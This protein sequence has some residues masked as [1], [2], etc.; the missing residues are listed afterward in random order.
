MCKLQAPNKNYIMRKKDRI[1]S[2]KSSKMTPFE[3]RVALKK[4]NKHNT[5][6]NT[7]LECG[8]GDLK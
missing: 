2:P 8:S 1:E 6:S 4:T 7:L 3:S 5:D